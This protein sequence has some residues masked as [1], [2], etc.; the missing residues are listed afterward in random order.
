[1]H[2]AVS[3]LGLGT[4]FG[5]PYI[6]SMLWRISRRT[7]PAGFIQ[8]C[9]PTLVAAPP[10]G[11]GWLHEVKHDGFRI[12]A[13]IARLFRDVKPLPF[14]S[15]FSALFALIGLGLGAGVVV[16]F[17]ETG[18]VPRLPTAV[19]STGLI[20]LAALSFACGMILDSVARGRRESKRL[21]Y[22]AAGATRN[23]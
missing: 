19:L 4:A 12:L 23:R 8:P 13:T 20:L 15:G 21:A 11:P 16:E 9:Q 2:G 6:R 1:M 17:M 7:Q 22:L 18:L 14:F 5:G 10:A 3:P